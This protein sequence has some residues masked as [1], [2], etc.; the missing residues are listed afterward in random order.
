MTLLKRLNS[1]YPQAPNGWRTIFGVSAFIALFLVVF[2]PFGLRNY[3]SDFATFVISGYGLVTFAVLV[4]DLIWLRKVLFRVFDEDGWTVKKQILWSSWIVVS[5]SMGNYLYS[6]GL[7]MLPSISLQGFFLFVLF[8]SAL[9]FF[10][11]TALTLIAQN[12]YLK[13][14]MAS[15]GEINQI[16]LKEPT[17]NEMT[18][19][20]IIGSG[21]QQ[22]KLAANNLIVMASE[23]N[24]IKVDHL[25]DMRA[26]STLCRDTLKRFEPAI[27]NSTLFR[28]HRAFIINLS[29]VEKVK[30]NSQGYTLK[31]KHIATEIPVARRYTKLFKQRITQHQ[32]G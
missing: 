26:K 23:G 24:Y 13:K 3:H 27:E 20:L 6:V 10:P 5:I 17:L 9:A 25:V 29:F 7:S 8:T 16:I 15:S 1:N 31:I 21:T 11:I 22:L 18:D 28:C 30:G 32:R 14:N 12:V 4:V 19:E 2:R